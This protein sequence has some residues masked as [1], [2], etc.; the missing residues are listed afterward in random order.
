[1]SRILLWNMDNANTFLKRESKVS[2]YLTGFYMF[3]NGKQ[4]QST[5]QT[6]HLLK[7]LSFVYLPTLTAIQK[8]WQG[9]C[10][11]YIR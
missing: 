10:D 6:A 5:I 9:G 8:R 7:Y 2:V 11:F 3:S 4:K 1:M